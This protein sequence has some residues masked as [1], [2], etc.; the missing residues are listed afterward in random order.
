MPTYPST[1]AERTDA[2]ELC[3]EALQSGILAEMYED[4]EWVRLLRA[5]Q[6][7]TAHESR[8]RGERLLPSS[9]CPGRETSSSDSSDSATV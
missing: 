5:Q 9:S 3:A 2:L 8:T 6:D 1:V 4:D 7:S